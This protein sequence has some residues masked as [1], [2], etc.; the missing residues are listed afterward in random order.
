[1]QCSIAIRE[2]RHL[3]QLGP[4]IASEQQSS[5]DTIEARFYLF[6]CGLVREQVDEEEEEWTVESRLVVFGASNA[7][8]ATIVEV[9]IN[10]LNTNIHSV[11]DTEHI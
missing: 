9:C 3:S 5:G 8:T 7:E 4:A 10:V 1:M 2:R 6:A 11:V